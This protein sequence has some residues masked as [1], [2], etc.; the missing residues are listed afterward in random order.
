MIIPSHSVYIRRVPSHWEQK[1]ARLLK[2]A[3]ELECHPS[4][5]YLKK[6]S[7]SINISEFKYTYYLPWDRS[8]VTEAVVS[9]SNKS[10]TKTS[11]G[12]V[13]PSGGGIDKIR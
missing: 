9:A 2:F 8:F 1:A 12:R 5:F 11:R 7:I 4:A 13:I 10:R 6:H 3:E